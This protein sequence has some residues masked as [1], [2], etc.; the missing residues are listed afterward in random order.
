METTKKKKPVAKVIGENGNVFVT[1]SICTT[2]L[3]KAG[4]RAEADELPG[5]VMM[6]GD[7]NEALRIMMEYCEFK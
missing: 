5:K 6:A 1:L 4:M 2:A 3:K 7:Y